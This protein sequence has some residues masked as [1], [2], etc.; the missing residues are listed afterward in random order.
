M[1]TSRTFSSAFSFDFNPDDGVTAGQMDFIG[2]AIHEIGHA[3]GFISG[4]DT[5]DYYGGPSGPGRASNINLNSYAVGSVLEAKPTAFRWQVDA[6]AVCRVDLF[7]TGG[8]RIWESAGVR[9]G[10]APFDARLS[11]GA[12]L[13]TVRCA[14]EVLGPFDFRV[15]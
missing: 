7:D 4:V 8:Q 5:Y 2:V 14:G 9:G 13:W 11:A 6:A 3:L 15:Q 12:Y 10:A 1:V